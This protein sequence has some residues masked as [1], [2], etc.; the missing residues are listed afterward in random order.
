MISL[1]MKYMYCSVFKIGNIFHI[2]IHYIVAG[3]LGE[4]IKH[5]ALPVKPNLVAWELGLWC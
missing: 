1:F 4:S 5:W 3:N 2:E